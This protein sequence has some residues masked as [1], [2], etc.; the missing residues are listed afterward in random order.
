MKQTNRNSA[1]T[2]IIKSLVTILISIF[3]LNFAYSQ[4]NQMGTLTN[5]GSFPSVSMVTDNIFFV[6]GGPS[7][8]PVIYKTTNGGTSFTQ[9]NTTGITL[10]LYSI[11][12]VDVNTIYVGDGGSAG[13]AGGNAKVYKTT[14]G[15]TNWTN[16]LSTGGTAGFINGIVF[17]R[18]NPQ[19]GII[20]SDPPNG[21]GQAY[22]LAKTTNGGLNWTVSSPARVTGNKSAQNSVFVID[23]NFY[24]FGLD[25]SPQMRYTTNGGT[26]WT[27]KTLTGAQGAT[28]FVTSI[29]FNNNK[30]N[31]VAAGY[32]TYNSIS[33]TTNGGVNWFAQA[34]PSTVPIGS[35]TN[36]GELKWIPGYNTVYLIVSSPTQTQSFKS[37]DGGATWMPLTF[38]N[39]GGVTHMDAVYTAGM[40]QLS[41]ISSPGPIF[42]ITDSPMP[43]K[44]QSFT[45]SVSGRDVNL[46][47]V[48]SMEENNSGFEIY[49]MST[50][51]SGNNPTDWTNIGFVHGNGNTN[52]TTVYNFSD[53]KLSSGK[54][55]YKIKQIDY[56]GNYEYFNLEGSVNIGNATKHEL[57]QNYPNPF[58]PTTNIDYQISQD[59]KVMLKVYDISGREVMTLVNTQQKAGYY[60]VPFN[61]T[62]LSSGNYFYKLIV[63][64]NGNETVITKKMTV[65]K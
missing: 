47:W 38:P 57:S 15:G 27:T 45:Y 20:Q 1:Q 25:V 61:A 33:R 26:T 22:W 32:G 35:G 64:S 42:K 59:S 62:N 18:S 56:N 51:L 28:G 54:Y 36:F 65:I 17:S 55:N 24:G 2:K 53:K 21:T 19:V 7:G 49:R 52:N 48:T 41:S 14:N 43:V 37:E 12:A 9:L 11:W 13:G 4:W 16:I 30:L 34:I 10:E 8:T 6:A 44:L 60:T 50:D 5:V 40:S 58:N 29:A 63:G 31:G 46:K 3:T 39:N 23:Q